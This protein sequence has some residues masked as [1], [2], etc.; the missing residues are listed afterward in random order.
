M[1]GFGWQYRLLVFSVD[2][3]IAQR[4]R[5]PLCAGAFPDAVHGRPSPLWNDSGL[6][7]GCPGSPQP[8]RIHKMAEILNPTCQP[9]FAPWKLLSPFVNF[10]DLQACLARGRSMPLTNCCYG[11]RAHYAAGI[12]FYRTTTI[13]I[14]SF[15]SSEWFP[16]NSNHQCL[17]LPPGAGRGRHRKCS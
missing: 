14:T 7:C 11:W 15:R 10:A 2:G 12:N 16:H 3:D 4:T 17:L 13:I 6:R 8:F 9:A 1:H 5:P